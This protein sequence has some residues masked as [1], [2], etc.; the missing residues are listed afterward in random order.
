MSPFMGRCLWIWV[1]ETEERLE[2]PMT[3]ERARATYYG[4]LN[5]QTKEFL[6]EEYDQGNAKN[7]VSF[8]EKLRAINPTSR[9]LIIWDGA[10]YHR[11][12]EM[13]EYLKE[14]NQT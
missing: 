9:L 13:K 1:G 2:I 11:Y 7:T 4:A 10:S 3:N 8:L 5:Y 14:N 6:V 12:K